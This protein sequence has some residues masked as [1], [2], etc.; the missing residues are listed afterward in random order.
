M[1][2][3]D[4][5]LLVRERYAATWVRVTA[6][7]RVFFGGWWTAELARKA[8]ELAREM[9]KRSAET[10]GAWPVSQPTVVGAVV[11]LDYRIAKTTTARDFR[12]RIADEFG[13]RLE[14]VGLDRLTKSDLSRTVAPASREEVAEV[15]EEEA[16]AKRFSVARIVGGVTG[17]AKFARTVVLL[18]VLGA[19]LLVVPRLVRDF[20]KATGD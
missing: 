9:F 5:E 3:P 11:V 1:P 17:A 4:T 15:R 2:I 6:M 7:E 14:D 20:R 10:I 19:G 8:E 13:L 16:E 18:G 12:R